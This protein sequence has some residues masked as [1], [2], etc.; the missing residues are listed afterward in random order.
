MYKKT[1]LLA[2]AAVT[3]LSIPLM[4]ST[5]VYADGEDSVQSESVTSTS[6]LPTQEELGV[7]D[8]TYQQLL[9]EY[10]HSK[11]LK[12][13]ESLDDPEQSETN[14]C[15]VTFTV[16]NVP[17]GFS[18][19][20]DEAAYIMISSDSYSIRIPATANEQYS[21][22]SYVPQGDYKIMLCAFVND[23]RNRWQLETP[24]QT[25]FTASPDTTTEITVKMSDAS[26]AEA[27]EN[28]KALSD[29]QEKAAEEVESTSGEIPQGVQSVSATSTPQEVV[30][31]SEINADYENKN[32]IASNPAE[33][34]AK[35]SKVPAIIAVCV[36]AGIAVAVI[37]FAIRFKRDNRDE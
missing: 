37:Y 22:T 31:M 12:L 34:V 13:T 33:T 35:K 36:L 23:N 10:E 3:A 28:I 6:S 26:V 15:P 29:D 21:H 32:L 16:A 1:R 4:I 8:E 19:I 30:S 18:T 2:L 9:Q 20:D 17:E 7:D 24:E 25:T 5:P 27:E 11:N 14:T